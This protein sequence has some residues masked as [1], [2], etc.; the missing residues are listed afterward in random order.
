MQPR[1]VTLKKLKNC[2][3]RGQEQDTKI[4]WANLFYIIIHVIFNINIDNT[5][6][7]DEDDHYDDV[8]GD[9]DGDHAYECC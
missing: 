8:D 4:R 3:P 2:C 1:E 9:D 7:D 5:I 6:N